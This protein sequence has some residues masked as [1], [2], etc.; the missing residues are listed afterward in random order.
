MTDAPLT[1]LPPLSRRAFL[2]AGLSAGF[3]GACSAA[4]LPLVTPVAHAAAPG[5][6][7]LV[8]IILRGA[9]DG[10]DVMTPYADPT[11]RALRPVLARDADAAGIDAPARD[12]ALDAYFALHPGL[13]PLLPLW[14]AG[15]LAAVHAVS[16]PYRDGR[17]HFDGQDVLENGAIAADDRRDGWLNRALGVLPGAPNRAEIRYAVAVGQRYM[18]ML[19]GA[20]PASS[21]SPATALDLGDDERRLLARLYAG[22][23]LFQSA[24]EEAALISAVGDGSPRPRRERPVELARFAAQMLSEESR[25]AAFSIG[26]WDTHLYQPRAI[27][28][29]L[30]DLSDALLTLKDELGPHWSRTAVL[31]ITEFGRTARE[32]GAEGTDHGSGG[33]ALLAGGAIRGGRIWNGPSGGPGSGFAGWP[34]LGESD[35]YENRDVRPTE[36]VRRLAAWLLVSLFDAPASAMST[37]VFPGVELGAEPPLLA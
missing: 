2:R 16:T 31:A 4:A 27:R 28:R 15:D 3:G 20:E 33:L 22:D 35:L 13:D 7:R 23:A 21:W 17:S 5:E 36:D 6:N 25:I 11:Y 10:L 30:K 12:R 37:R 19:D 26:G 32:N 24:A 14:A 9:M 29:P 1:G 34:G 8:V 18:L